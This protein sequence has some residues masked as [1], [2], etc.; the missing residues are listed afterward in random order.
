MKK[1]RILYNFS[2]EKNSQLIRE[3]G[4]SFEVIIATLEKGAILDIL[5]HPNGEKYPQQKI[6]VLEMNDYVY[7]VPFVRTHD[8][9][10][11]LKTAFPH[12]KLT[13]KYLGNKE[14]IDHD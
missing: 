7:A 2:A 13:K 10:I 11:F 6:Y 5:E 4:I 14:E 12:R 1:S 3:R 8:H 9:E